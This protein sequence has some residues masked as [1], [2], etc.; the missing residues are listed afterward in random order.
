MSRRY[1]KVHSLLRSVQD[2]AAERRTNA[3]QIAKATGLPL[4]SI[5]KLLR[6]TH[7]PTLRNVEVILSGLGLSL[8][9]K[10][11]D[12]PTIRPATRVRPAEKK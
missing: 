9:L 1:D 3:Y 8:Y 5:Q 11:E 10:A 6:Q 2:A 7:N 12:A 4:R